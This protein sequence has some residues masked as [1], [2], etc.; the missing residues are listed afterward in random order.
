MEFYKVNNI[1]DFL[2]EGRTNASELLGLKGTIESYIK[3]FFGPAIDLKLDMNLNIIVQGD[4]KAIFFD[5]TALLNPLAKL[6]DID[7]SA[8]NP[9]DF[10]S[11]LRVRI[12]NKLNELKI[13]KSEGELVVNFPTIRSIYA[14]KKDHIEKSVQI[15]K[16]CN[17]IK[18][19]NQ[20][21][22]IKGKKLHELGISRTEH[23]SNL[24]EAHTFSLQSFMIAYYAD[25][26]R[27]ERYIEYLAANVSQAM[28]PIT[29]MQSLD[30]N[31]INAYINNLRTTQ[32]KKEL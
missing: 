15:E 30:E 28:M 22:L 21:D 13:I 32:K 16:S 9:E 10:A 1:N 20:A 6:L 31:K 23:A 11:I 8:I 5:Q 19:S 18:P 17:S 7:T 26:E 24:I 25:I 14:N 27:I 3:N 2:K 4:Y 12:Q 29:T